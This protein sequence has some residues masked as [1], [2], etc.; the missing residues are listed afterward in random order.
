MSKY[1]L[2]PSIGTACLLLMLSQTAGAQIV[3]SDSFDDGQ[4]ST[5]WSAPLETIEFSTSDWTLDY[6]FDYS[7]IQ[8]PFAGNAPIPSAPNSTGGS[9]IGV[10]M[11][12]NNTEQTTG[13]EGE[14]IGIVSNFALPSGDFSITADLF[15][16]WNGG[17]GSTEYSIFGANHDGSNNVPFPFN[18]N[19]GSG[20]AWA[21]DSDGDS[22]T[23]LYRFEEG[24]G[25]TGLGGYEA[26]PS[27]SIPNVPTGSPAPVGIY[28]QW[29]EVQIEVVDGNA[30]FSI[31]GYLIDTVASA[32]TGGGVLLGHADYFNSVNNAIGGFTNGSIWDNIVVTELGAAVAGDF[33]GD[34][35]VDNGDL[36]LLL[37]N[38][39]LATVPPEW[40]NGFDT[41]VDNGELNALLGNW[42]FGVGVAV[43]EPSAA[44]LFVTG[45]VAAAA[46]RRS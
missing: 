10:Y 22:G 9:T 38:W 44:L 7:Q 4:A 41:P 32:F 14:A 23:D 31:N 13:D 19:A 25:Q 2:L 20:I 45:L 24:I 30:A 3:F 46:R 17:G 8:N 26:I 43:P 42:G 33:N 11:T 29:V 36:N 28:S 39:G 16:F 18:V 6:A 34:G 37:G 1:F 35:K 40:T 5:R 12:A 27:G 21:A 15:L